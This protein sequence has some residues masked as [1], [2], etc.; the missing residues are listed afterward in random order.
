[1]RSPWGDETS[2]SAAAFECASKGDGI[3]VFEIAAMGNARGDSAEHDAQR[4]QRFGDK[5]RG[6]LSLDGG[7]GRDDDL[8]GVFFADS[9]Q[10]WVQ[11][12]L[13]GTHAG[14]RIEECVQHVVATAKRSSAFERVDVPGA[15]HHAEGLIAA[16]CIRTDPA[17]FAAGI[18]AADRTTANALGQRCEC[19]TER[20]GERRSRREQAV[21][22]TT[23]GLLS[24]ARKARE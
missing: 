22:H 12:K 2:E 6:R 24:N 20:L 16:C 19:F 9:S 14:Q 18:G 10:E 4:T 23:C 13:L 8:A 17:H 3:D 7:W 5:Q 15:C 11:R 21:G 1:M